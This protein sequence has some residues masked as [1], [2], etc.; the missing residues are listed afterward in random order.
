LALLKALG[1]TEVIWAVDGNAALAHLQQQTFDVVLMDVQMPDLDG[2]QVT[3]RL[4][5]L[6]LVKQP[7]VI[8][9]T[10]NVFPE[11]RE[12]CVLAGMNDFLSK[13][14]SMGDLQQALGRS[15]QR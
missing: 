14:I 10:A 11:D 7:W 3:Q 8:A 15:Q 6:P 4:R 5:T 13:P 9:L 2:L 1:Q 12:A